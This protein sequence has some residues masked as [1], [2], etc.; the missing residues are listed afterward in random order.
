MISSIFWNFVSA[1]AARPNNSFSWYLGDKTSTKFW[2]VSKA[3]FSFSFADS[4]IFS[5]SR[6]VFRASWNLL[7]KI[8]ISCSNN[9]F[10]SSSSLKIDA[11]WGIINFSSW[12]KI[13]LRKIIFSLIWNLFKIQVFSYALPIRNAGLRTLSKVNEETILV[14]LSPSHKWLFC[15]EGLVRVDIIDENAE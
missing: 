5:R 3:D 14:F 15:T 9:S 6:T 1:T 8:G 13:K 11:K 10:S 7:H 4:R 12:L 2:F